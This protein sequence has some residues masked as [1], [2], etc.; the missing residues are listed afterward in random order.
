MIDLL[1]TRRST[2]KFTQ[3]PIELE[4]L[5]L[6]KEALLRS[7]TSKNSNACE[8]I[9][10]DNPAMLGKLAQSKPSGAGA[11]LTASLAVVVLANESQ[12]GAWVEDCAIASIL[13]QITA[14]SMG[15]GSCWVQIR[16]RDHNEHKSSETYVSETL[17][18]P[19]NYR[20][21]SIVAIGYP[22]RIHEG[23]PL[24]DLYFSKIH[25]I[26]STNAK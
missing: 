14:H 11:L 20:V 3:Q 24:S 25:I 5:E 13:L 10:V 16:G 7:P 17:N 6:M 8:F 9:F 4:K 1:R 19:D 22:Q 26:D 12:T 21:L 23:K 15:L 2:R 18:I